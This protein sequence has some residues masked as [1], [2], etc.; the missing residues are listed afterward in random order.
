MHVVTFDNGKLQIAI[1]RCGRD[2]MPHALNLT[3]MPA[4]ILIHIIR[5]NIR[6]REAIVSSES[7]A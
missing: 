7:P 4:A 2:L 5:S 1:K 3:I 6:S